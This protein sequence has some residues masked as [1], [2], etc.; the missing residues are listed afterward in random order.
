MKQFILSYTKATFLKPV[1]EEGKLT[2][3]QKLQ[4]RAHLPVC[5]LCRLFEKQTAFISKNARHSHQH[6]TAPLSQKAKEKMSKA[7]MEITSGE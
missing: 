4:L 2:F 6:I 3:S 5:S 7:I 1:R